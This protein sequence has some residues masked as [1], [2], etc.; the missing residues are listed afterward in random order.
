MV[1]H[2]RVITAQ[3]TAVFQLRNLSKHKRALVLDSMKRAHRL[4]EGCH[5]PL[6]QIPSL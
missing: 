6:H 3:K 2:Q 4:T 5:T 1:Q